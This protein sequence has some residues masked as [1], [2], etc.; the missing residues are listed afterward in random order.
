LKLKSST[1]VVARASCDGHGRFTLRVK[2][3]RTVKRALSHWRG[4]LKVKAT[5]KLGPKSSRRTFVLG[6]RS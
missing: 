1:L 5:L 6:G 2:P 3:S 4:A